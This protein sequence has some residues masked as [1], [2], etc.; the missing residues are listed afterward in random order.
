MYT[1][2]LGPD[3]AQ[4]YDNRREAIKAARSASQTSRHPV[5]V[6]RTDGNERMIYQRGELTEATYVTSDR[7]DRDGRLN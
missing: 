5:K 7:R 2:T 6:L 4:S 1:V 3:Q